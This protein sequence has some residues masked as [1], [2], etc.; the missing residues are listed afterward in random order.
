ML[1]EAMATAALATAPQDY[2]G[3]PARVVLECEEQAA[4][5]AIRR[6]GRWVLEP[7]GV[8]GQPSTYTIDV[9]GARY[10][11]PDNPDRAYP[12]LVGHGSLRV[13][14]DTSLLTEFAAPDLLYYLA[15][16]A[17]PSGLHV[18]TVNDAQGSYTVVGECRRVE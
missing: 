3:W 2:N 18:R 8:D 13:Q 1:L 11:D 15:D 7:V 16:P 10:P 9:A 17:A 4:T 5:R 12:V 14:F 6:D